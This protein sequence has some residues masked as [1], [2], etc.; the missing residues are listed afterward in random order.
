MSFRARLLATC[1]IAG[2]SALAACSDGSD[3]DEGTLAPGAGD[4]AGNDAEGHPTRAI[5]P[6][7]TSPE[8]IELGGETSEF[9]GVDS[10]NP[11]SGSPGPRPTKTAHDLADPALARWL[12]LI[13]GAHE[14]PL[15][16]REG[17]LAAGISG[18]A[19]MT[20]V[21]FEITALSAFDLKF[22]SSPDRLLQLDVAVQLLTADR[23]LEA[24][25]ENALL[26]TRASD[27]SELARSWGYRPVVPLEQARG[28]LD[29]NLDPEREV[30]GGVSLSL[31]ISRA[32]ARGQLTA[33]VQYPEEP[34]RRLIT[35]SFPDDG[36]GLAE[37]PIELGADPDGFAQSASKSL[38]AVA[39]ALR[40]APGGP[41]ADATLQTLTLALGAAEHACRS[42]SGTILYAPMRLSDGAFDLKQD[43]R[44]ELG[45]DAK[46]GVA[47]AR[48][49]T[50]RQFIAGDR[51][52]ALTGILPAA[53]TA[54][55]A[56]L[57]PRVYLL[58]SD[59]DSLF[60][61]LAL[62]LFD[63]STSTLPLLWCSGD[64]CD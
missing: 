46:G 19:E 62:E 40:N 16:W 33:A 30:K 43:A 38:E 22:E 14:L 51:L 29:L 26:L 53:E 41:T 23:A 18:H 2:G 9:D 24:S 32:G 6:G 52:G 37:S 57:A 34:V 44:I 64:A 58:L 42:D 4:P 61:E 3:P 7:C 63:T 31:A 39:A 17:F 20:K 21:S 13:E 48:L 50:R 5:C 59:S 36:C 1:L 60:G 45:A 35:G 49:W 8:P 54:G 25:F 56:Y 27:G 11:S 47:S 28:T 12:E 55:A 10:R 15:R